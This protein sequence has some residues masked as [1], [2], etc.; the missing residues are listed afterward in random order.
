VKQI[1]KLSALLAG[2]VAL[3]LLLS[4]STALAAS[5]IVDANSYVTQIQNLEVADDVEGVTIYNVDFLYDTASNLYK[6]NGFDFQSEENAVVAKLAVEAALNSASPI[7]IGASPVGNTQFFIGL[8]VEQSTF[9]AGIG[10]EFISGL[11]DDCETECVAGTGTGK[12]NENYT[13]AIF[14]VVGGP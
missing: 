8:E 1:K 14:T 13:F 3:G 12:A 5:V 11:W 7:P 10:S 6:I 2:V 9:V 4:A